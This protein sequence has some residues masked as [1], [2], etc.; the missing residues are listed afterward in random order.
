MK[1]E[2]YA[3]RPLTAGVPSLESRG[4][5][6]QDSN[7]TTHP[8]TKGVIECVDRLVRLEGAERN[9][10]V[11]GCGPQPSAVKDL[12]AAG[13]DAFAIEPVPDSV[14]RAQAFLAAPHRVQ[15]GACERL[16]FP[17]AAFGLVLMESVLE[18][19]D[20]PPLALNEVFRVLRPGGVLYI[21]TTNRWKLSLRGFTGE[22]SVP[23]INWFP[24]VVQ[25]SYVFQMLHYDP[26]LANFNARPAVHWFTYPDLCRLGRDAGFAQFYS[27]LDLVDTSSPF[28]S[29]SR[30]RRFVLDKVRYRPWL[31]GLALTQS[32]GAIFMYK[33]L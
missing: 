28:V 8:F 10:L 1:P 18:H 5:D 31:R 32:G 2:L 11:V 16:P 13:F 27:P 19:V 26:A 29:G 3:G 24:R 23:F 7:Q 25:E 21:Y 4:A 14:A 9:A 33:R 6:I 12:L 20:S 17:D 22:Y 15:Q 30:L